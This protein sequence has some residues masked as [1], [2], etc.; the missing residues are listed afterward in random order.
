[1]PEQKRWTVT[2][3]CHGKIL[4]DGRRNQVVDVFQIEELDELQ[5][6]IER[7]PDFRAIDR[8]EIRYAW[9]DKAEAL[10]ERITS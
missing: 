3:F 1:M 2:V 6:L 7:G 9:P 8:I 10:P 5:E 4:R